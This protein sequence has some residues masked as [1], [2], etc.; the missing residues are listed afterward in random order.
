MANKFN[1]G[2]VNLAELLV[3]PIL[4]LLGNPVISTGVRSCA[5]VSHS[6]QHWLQ[7]YKRWLIMDWHGFLL[8]SQIDKY[9][10]LDPNTNHRS[11]FRFEEK[12]LSPSA[13]KSITPVIENSG[14]GESR[15]QQIF[16][17]Q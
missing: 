3:G 16:K 14:A 15:G 6:T 12:Q 17:H 8:F 7:G 10:S 4:I 2:I 1:K 13:L 5:I 11:P 9:S